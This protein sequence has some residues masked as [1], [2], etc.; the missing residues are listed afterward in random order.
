MEINS[1]DRQT[2]TFHV[3]QPILGAM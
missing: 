2:T 1:Q 3:A